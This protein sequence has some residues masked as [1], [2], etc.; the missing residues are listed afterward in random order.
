MKVKLQNNFSSGRRGRWR[1][2]FHE[3]PDEMI[4]I[5][6][7]TA[8]IIEGPAKGKKRKGYTDRSAAP[9]VEVPPGPE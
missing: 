8:V 5:L 9:P 7:S 6:P 1:K 3:M 2:G 4:D